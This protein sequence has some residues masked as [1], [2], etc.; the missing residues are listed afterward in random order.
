M[1]RLSWFILSFMLIQ[2]AFAQ[3]ETDKKLQIRLQALVETNDGF[4]IAETDLNLRGPGEFFGTR[5]S[6]MPGG[7]KRGVH[8]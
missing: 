7:E 5:Q 6:G 2:S 1:R 3:S 4:Q 8:C